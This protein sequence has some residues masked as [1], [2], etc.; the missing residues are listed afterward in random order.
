MRQGVAKGRPFWCVHR[1]FFVVA[2]LPHSFEPRTRSVWRLVKS[3]TCVAI[4]KIACYL[5]SLSYSN[6]AGGLF[7]LYDDSSG[8]GK[9]HMISG[10]QRC[11]LSPESKNICNLGL[12]ISP[13]VLSPFCCT[14]DNLDWLSWIVSTNL[15]K[16][17]YRLKMG[18]QDLA[19]TRQN[20]T[21][22][23][24]GQLINGTKLLW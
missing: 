2:V 7:S 12:D 6:K 14:D 22:L 13:I 24:M 8:E 9:S 10:L 3:S 15:R 17:V 21:Q 5:I 4:K 11:Y 1:E 20:T 23:L 19:S 18:L 16:W